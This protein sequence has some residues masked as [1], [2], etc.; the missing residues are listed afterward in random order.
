MGIC[1]IFPENNRKPAIEQHRL[2]SIR[3]G[4]DRRNSSRSN[5]SRGLRVSILRR[6]LSTSFLLGVCIEHHR[7]LHSS[8][9]IAGHM[10]RRLSCCRLPHQRPKLYR[11][12][13]P[14]LGILSLGRRVPRVDWTSF[15]SRCRH[16]NIRRSYLISGA[17]LEKF[18]VT[19]YGKMCRNLMLSNQ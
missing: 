16:Q 13:Q 17:K 12:R 3:L 10:R 18:R 8:P 4:W 19:K 1:R 14:L 2:Q 6:N 11:D 7:A 9:R 5:S 15:Q